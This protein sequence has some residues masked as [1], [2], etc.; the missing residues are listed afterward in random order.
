MQLKSII[1]V[2]ANLL[3]LS[4]RHQLVLHP[5][6]YRVIPP[7]RSKKDIDGRQSSRGA[8][9][10]SPLSDAV[11]RH[12]TPPAARSFLSILGPSGHVAG[13]PRLAIPTPLLGI[14]STERPD[15]GGVRLSHGSGLLGQPIPHGQQPATSDD[16]LWLFNVVYFSASQPLALA[17]LQVLCQVSV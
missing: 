17:R 8:V 1:G 13:T 4:V 2:S 10:L 16:R 5:V 14:Q 11:Q 15:I 6:N 9:H 12:L 7:R 3:Y